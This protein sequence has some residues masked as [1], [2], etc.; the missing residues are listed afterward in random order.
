MDYDGG[1]R[2]RVN[3]FFLTLPPLGWLVFF[4]LI[5]ALP[6]AIEWQGFTLLFY[7]IATSPP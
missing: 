5:P 1:M 7:L 6:Y 4:F 2:R 3:E